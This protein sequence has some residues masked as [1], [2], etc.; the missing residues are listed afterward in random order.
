VTN[1]GTTPLWVRLDSTGY[2][3]YAPQ[4]SANVLQVERHILATDGSRNRSLR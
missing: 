3:E 4:P 2:P 1:T